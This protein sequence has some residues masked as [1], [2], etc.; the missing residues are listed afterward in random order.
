VNKLIK[1]SLATG[2]GVALLLGGAGTFMSWNDVETVDGGTINTGH[3]ELA[4]DTD[5][6]RW[7]VN[8]GTKM[9][10]SQMEKTYLAA[11]GDEIVYEVPVTVDA[12][13][14]HL[15][16]TVE[17]QAGALTGDQVATA[18]GAGALEA[19]LI[20][21]ADSQDFFGTPTHGVYTLGEGEGTATARITLEFN[22]N[23]VGAENAAM[24][25]KIALGDLTVALTQLAGTSTGADN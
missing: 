20:P 19:E 3:L 24:D 8:G 10:T 15:T 16:A 4:A 22:D 11:P 17:A 12:A 2:A 9:T 25:Q 14:T 1:G 21:D 5:D 18:F 6:V 13:G 23:G 7:S